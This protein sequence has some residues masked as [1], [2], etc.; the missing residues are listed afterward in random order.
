MKIRWTLEALN[1]IEALEEYSPGLGLKV[2]D[3]TEEKLR[4]FAGLHIIVTIYDSKKS[5][6]KVHRMVLQKNV[7][8][9]VYYEMK[10]KTVNVVA[11][12][13]ARQHPIEQEN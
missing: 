10:G 2:F 11:V 6:R 3:L 9:K 8:Y 4:R 13:H 7:P 1:F 5:A 12:R